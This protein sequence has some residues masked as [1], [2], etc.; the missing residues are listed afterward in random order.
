MKHHRFGII[1]AALFAA[2][3]VAAPASAAGV[4]TLVLGDFYGM[5]DLT[6][7]LNDLTGSD[8][9]FDHVN[10]GA[11]NLRNGLP[12]SS[13]LAGYNS[14][15]VFSDSVSVDYNVLSDMLGAYV[16]N[17]GGV[18]I[19]TF[20]GQ[21]IGNSGGLLNS[22]G[23][24]PLNNQTFDAYNFHSLGS[25]DSAD[26]LMQGVASLSSSTYNGDY[27]A[28][29]DAGATLAASWDDGRP[30]AAYNAGRNVAAITIYPNAFTFGHVSG[31]YQRLFSNALAFTAGTSAGAVP[32]PATWSLLIGGFGM[33]GFAMRRRGTALLA[34]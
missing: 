24:N 18:V 31:D 14:V 25:Y 34:G 12:M 21:E 23:Y 11:Y 6:P 28:G 17:G 19:G 13:M 22:T 10:S 2:A 4:K 26:P 16:N 8:G 15:L 9:R 32:E 1:A 5:D 3:I 30:L 27:N 33:I 7:I 20:W 29:L